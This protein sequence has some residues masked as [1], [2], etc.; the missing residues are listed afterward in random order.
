MPKRRLYPYAPA[1]EPVITFS[2]H[3]QGICQQN[4][5]DT[6]SLKTAQLLCWFLICSHVLAFRGVNV[7]IFMNLDIAQAVLQCQR[8]LW[9]E[10]WLYLFVLSEYRCWGSVSWKLFALLHIM[11]AYW[12]VLGGNAITSSICCKK[13][14]KV[15]QGLYYAEECTIRIEDCCFISSLCLEKF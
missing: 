10:F 7:W 1:L 13:G 4:C 9:L 12:Q 3:I 6:L 8:N 2:A 5:W 11:H 15:T 14:K